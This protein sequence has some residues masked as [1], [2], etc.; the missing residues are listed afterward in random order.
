MTEQAELARPEAGK[1]IETVNPATGEPGKIYPQTSLD[2][3]RAAASAARQAFLEWRRT[4]FAERS[5]IIR[6]AAEILRARKD[7][8]ARLMT[9]EMGKTV[10][11]GRAEVEKCA[12]HCDWFAEHA[13]GYLAEQPVDLGQGET[14]VTFNPIGVVLAVMPW[15][16][17]FWQVFRFAA[18]ALM[19]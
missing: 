3:A 11:D 16:F 9:E 6:K 10:T 7:E 5:A 17:P 19:A 13:E 2:E 15:N 4:R 8:F 14:F 1:T 18:P 12:A